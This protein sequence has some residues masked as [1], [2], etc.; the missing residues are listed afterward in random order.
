M[1][2]SHF[3]QDPQKSSELI[4]TWEGMLCFFANVKLLW[5]TW[6]IVPQNIKASSPNT[7]KRVLAACLLRLSQGHANGRGVN[8]H[9]VDNWPHWIFA[10]VISKIWIW[11][12]HPPPTRDNTVA[13]S[14]H[15]TNDSCWPFFSLSFLFLQLGRTEKLREWGNTERQRQRQQ[16]TYFTVK[17]TPCW[18][19]EGTWTRSRSR[20]L[21]WA[22]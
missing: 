19:G 16:Q 17:H 2:V 5:C 11:G 6:N 20:S 21:I 9:L 15:W 14:Q 7:C 4:V 1:A 13:I 22:T 12:G 18:W 3:S 8:A 10:N